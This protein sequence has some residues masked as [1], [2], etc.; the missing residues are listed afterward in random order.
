VSAAFTQLT[1]DIERQGDGL[2]VSVAG[3]LDHDSAPSLRAKLD[4][5]VTNEVRKIDLSLASVTFIDSAALQVFVSVHDEMR[6]RGGGLVI[7]DASPLVSRILDVTR[8][9]SLFGQ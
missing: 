9:G 2:H 1:V 6:R 8:L 3:D 5:A 4:E 7:T